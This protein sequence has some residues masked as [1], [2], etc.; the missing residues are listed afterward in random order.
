MTSRVNDDLLDMAVSRLQLGQST[1]DIQD[2]Y[3]TQADDLQPLLRATEALLAVRSIDK[4][5]TESL[6][7]DQNDFLAQVTELQLQPVSPSPIVRLKGWISQKTARPSPALSGQQKEIRNM[8]VLALKVALILVVAFGSLGGTLAAAADSLPGTAV[9]PFKLAMEEFRLALSKDPFV[10]ASRHLEFTQERIQEIV[11]IAAKDDV[12]EEGLLTR[13]QTHMSTAFQITAQVGD[14][15][16][17]ELLTQSQKIA[18]VSRS[19]LEVAQEQAQVQVQE[20]LQQASSMMAQWQREAEN[21]LQ[22]L[23]YFR[24]HYGPGRLPCEDDDCQ[25][26]YGDGGQE[27]NQHQH[28]PGEPPCESD[29]CQPPYGDGD[30]EQNQNTE[31][32]Q[33]QGDTQYQNQEQSGQGTDGSQSGGSGDPGGTGS[34]DNSNGSAGASGGSGGSGGG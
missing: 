5:V 25:P 17:R 30:Q 33:A 34:P 23:E 15:E 11:R 16:M 6:L 28:G 4:P 14:E 12:P 8:S 10:Q 27:Q 7:S 19:D 20:R 21:G 9:Y 29:D 31:Q 1:D 3:P 26:P 32:N 22:D 18:E 13:M 24:W 2:A